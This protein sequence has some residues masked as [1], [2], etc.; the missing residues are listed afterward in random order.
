VIAESARGRFGYEEAGSGTPVILL[1]GFPHDRTLWE[2][3][4]AAPPVGARLIAIDLPGFGE[5]ESAAVP[6]LDAWADWVVAALDALGIERAVFCGLSM[7]GYLCFA[8][9]RRH[10]SRVMGFVLADTR[11]GADTLEAQDKRVAMQATVLTDGVGK[12]A[13]AMMPGMIG[14]TTRETR[15]R[16]VEFVDAMLRRASVGAVHDAL[17]A[18]RTRPDSTPQLGSITVPVLIICGDEDVLT[19]PKESEAMRAAIPVAQLAIIPGAGHVSNVE[20][21]AAFNAVLSGFIQARFP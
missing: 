18:L 2:A 7:G 17:D 11:A 10:P 8:L 12:I 16:A 21:P 3:Q 19:P 14:K 15:P 13:D 4:L 9:W 6:S 1:H 20:H 5:S